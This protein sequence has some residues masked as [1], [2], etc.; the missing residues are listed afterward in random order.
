ML[1]ACF[2]KCLPHLCADYDVFC[3]GRPS[4]V[5]T[6][7]VCTGSPVLWVIS[8]MSLLSSRPCDS[9]AAVGVVLQHKWHLHEQNTWQWHW[10]MHGCKSQVAELAPAALPQNMKP[11]QL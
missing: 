5:V 3:F 1:A 8:A 4:R 7:Y 2:D 11:W 9:V 6:T 10:Q